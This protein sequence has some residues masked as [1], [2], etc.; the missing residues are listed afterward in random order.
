MQAPSLTLKIPLLVVVAFWLCIWALAYAIS[1][2]LRTDLQ[3]VLSDQQS[4]LLSHLAAQI[5][6]QLENRANLLTVLAEGIAR[7][8]ALLRDPDALQV[9]LKEHPA[10]Y[11]PFS[12]GS[13]VFDR[14][15]RAIADYPPNG[16]RGLDYSDRDFFRAPIAGEPIISRLVV[17]KTLKTPLFAI[18][19]PVV[20]A[21]G[22]TVAVLA[23]VTNLSV[24]NFLGKLIGKNVGRT[25]GYLIVSPSDRQIVMA[26][27]QHRIFE[28]VDLE[29]EP[30]LQRFIGGYQG[31][32]I[33][34]NAEGIEELSTATVLPATGWIL[35][36]S[37]PTSEAFA[38]IEHLEQRIYRVTA[39]LSI[40]FAL[41]VGWIVRRQLAPLRRAARQIAAMGS[42][43][44]PRDTLPVGGADEIGQLFASFN[45]L[46]QRIAA[47][48]AEADRE[49]AKFAAIFD[50]TPD[51]TAIARIADGQLLAVSRSFADYFGCPA[52]E[53]VGRSAYEDELNH[54]WSAADGMAVLRQ[55]LEANGSVI[56][57]EAEVHRRGGQTSTVLLSGKLIEIDSEDCCIIELH[58]ITEKK[59]ENDRLEEIAHIDALTSLPNRRLLEDRMQLALAQSQRARTLMAVCYIDLDAFKPVNDTYGHEC[60]DRLLVEVAERLKKTVRG[61]DTVARLGGDEFVVLLT[62]LAGEEECLGVL[63]RMIEV[64][65]A[66]YRVHD[67]HQIHV[68]ASIGVTIYPNDNADPETL[69]RHADH[70]MYAAKQAGKDRYHLFDARLE[71]SVEARHTMMKRIQTALAA[72]ELRLYYHP[73]VDCRRGVVVGFEALIRWE[74]P[75]LGLLQPA[76][77]VPLIEADE[78]ALAVGGWVIREALRQLSAWNKEGYRLNLSINAFLHHL[79]HPDFFAQLSASLAEHAD[80]SPAQF[81]I[82][83]VENTP[84][85]DMDAI[86]QVVEDCRRLGIS[87]SLDDFGT[88]YSSLDY[89]RHLPAQEIKIDQSFVR[90]ML[91][92]AED[93]AIVEAVI[94]LGKAFHRSIVAE[95]VET[96]AHVRSLMDLGCDLMQGYVFARPMPADNVLPWLRAFHPE[97]AANP[98]A[99]A[100]AATS[101]G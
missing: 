40:A 47:S 88:A 37:L 36:A 8:P 29:R 100:G 52:S 46:Q 97:P 2:A 33:G 19:V 72:N 79:L 58:D 92:N 38:A 89:L 53:L 18:G 69:L 1:T 80:V 82:E 73:K 9:F 12:G 25:G 67:E 34:R 56:G 57:M 61:G 95:G 55:R 10:T 91:E 27:R 78:L 44:S 23:G 75:L 32:D 22:K 54:L 13:V 63:D 74:N 81:T 14:S 65:A 71:Q 5:N 76:E 30:M 21:S 50:L 17:G 94:G 86:H 24:P 87:F 45:R 64:V 31:T 15:G 96:S 48:S 77:F 51:P 7:Q 90:N 49:R 41:V 39:L 93:R 11:V 98:S 3:E 42:T 28:T 43:A 35:I 85:K 59:R 60:G 26:T 83:I 20:D 70:A 4:S 68:S 84:L 66:P 6:E 16:R 99:Q 62:G 101:E